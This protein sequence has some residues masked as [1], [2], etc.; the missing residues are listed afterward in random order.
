MTWF[1]K[2]LFVILLSGGGVS[3]CVVRGLVSNPA[4][5]SS[6]AVSICFLCLCWYYYKARNDSAIS[7][8]SDNVY[9]LG[10]LFTLVALV[11]S[12]VTLFMLDS[13]QINAAE[14]TEK[15][16]GSFGIALI[17][18]IFGILFR[19]LLLQREG[20][21]NI[22]ED[23]EK[24]LQRR[25]RWLYTP[26]KEDRLELSG[27]RESLADS[28]FKLRSELTQT[29]ADVSVFR[30]AV[31]QSTNETTQ[32]SQKARTEINRQMKEAAEEQARMF[33]TLSASMVEDLGKA[34]TA[35]QNVVNNLQITARQA[36]AFSSKS[37]SLTTGVEQVVVLLEK[38]MPKIEQATAVL[39]DTAITFSDSLS[40]ASK[41]M[42]QYTQQLEQLVTALRAVTEHWQSINPITQDLQNIVNDLQTTARNTKTLAAGFDPLQGSLQQTLTVL[43]AAVNGIKQAAVALPDT[44]RT[45]SDS[46]NKATET[47]P[48]YTQQFDD[49][50]VVLRKEAEQ[51]QL[52]SQ[53]VRMSLTQAIE[54]LT[55]VVRDS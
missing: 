35:L 8:H 54:D 29:I 2:N 46:L 48:Q 12:L 18:T 45:F 44:T 43:D 16:I 3:S 22:P 20:A 24:Q 50:V 7:Y 26:G 4:H 10:L 53:E 19:V 1:N 36:E 6:W 25:R 17:S 9:Y 42:P 37:D 49:L 27:P 47:M 14:R 40:Q 38:A 28:S 39:P 52:M 11:Y 21:E 13:E 5:G 31:I 15:L 33:S 23:A 34:A 41:I 30:H 51:W 32:E 55:R